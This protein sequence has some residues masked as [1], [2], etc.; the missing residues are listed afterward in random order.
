MGGIAAKSSGQRLQQL[1]VVIAGLDPAIHADVRVSGV[2]DARIMSVH[3]NECSH[4]RLN[5]L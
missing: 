5:A 4:Q 1:S 2:M 3:D